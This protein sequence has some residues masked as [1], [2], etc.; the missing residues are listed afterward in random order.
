M[1]EKAHQLKPSNFNKI[2]KVVLSGVATVASFLF[3]AAILALGV[4]ASLLYWAIGP[5]SADPFYNRRLLLLEWR[6]QFDMIPLLYKLI[7]IAILVLTFYRI[8]WWFRAR[9]K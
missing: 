6:G 4:L 9:R 7:F 2:A 8:F 5:V 3:V 1:T